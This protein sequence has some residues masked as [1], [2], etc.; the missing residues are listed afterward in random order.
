MPK[1]SSKAAGAS[2]G[3]ITHRTLISG[4]ST[5]GKTTS[6]LCTWRSSSVAVARQ[7]LLDLE[8]R[9]GIGAQQGARRRAIGAN[10]LRRGCAEMERGPGRARQELAGRSAL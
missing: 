3:L 7:R 10:E 8:P 1:R 2:F 5:M 9:V 4:P 6:T